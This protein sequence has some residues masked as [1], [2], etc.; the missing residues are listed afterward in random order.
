MKKLIYIVTFTTLNI[1]LGSNTLTAE[2]MPL[3]TD[4]SE[5]QVNEKFPAG[6]ATSL[7]KM[8]SNSFTYPSTIMEPSRQ[9]DFMV[10]RGFFRKLWVSSPSS[11]KASDGLG[12][13]YNARSCATCHVKNGRGHPPQQGDNSVS[14]FLRLSIPPQNKQEEALLSSNKAKFI[15]DPIYGSQLQ[16][17][18]VQGQAAEGKLQ[19]S[20]KD[21]PFHF[22]DGEI[23]TLKKPIYKITDLAYG[24]LHPNIMTSTR[25]APPMIGLGLLEA[26]SEEDI[27]SLTDEHDSNHDGISGKPNQVWSKTLNKISLGRFGYKAGVAT[28]DEQNQEAFSGDL[29]I[30]TPL[31]ENPWGECTKRQ[32]ICRK[33]SHGNDPQYNN[34]EADKRVTDAVLFF[35][36]NIAVPTRRNSNSPDVLAGKKSFYEIGCSA[37]HQPSFKTHQA[38]QQSANTEQQIW[39]YTDMLLHD[40]GKGLADQRPEG[41]ANEQEWR[42]APLWGIGLTKIVNK[43]SGFLHDGRARTLQEAI[44]WHG[45]EAET[46]QQKYLK[47]NKSQRHNLISFV[48]S[49]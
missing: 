39:P 7:K 15:P 31:N 8:N 45:G 20:Y 25:V 33:A 11:T 21:I 13:L 30:S 23:V 28:L 16:S 17:F 46:S 4:F 47:M 43:R 49:L 35:T 6:K 41:N 37:C 34:L 9:L 48:E 18:A 29:G 27:L 12:P 14:I 22:N 36:Q 1:A 19:V 38:K 32:N 10:G 42:T 24:D 44:L 2:V 40:M 5:A 3:S 26:I